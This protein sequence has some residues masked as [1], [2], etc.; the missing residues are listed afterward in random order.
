MISFTDKQNSFYFTDTSLKKILLE[1][2]EQPLLI[3]P[4][5]R[6]E[7]IQEINLL[8]EKVV[9][10]YITN[11]QLEYL[12]KIK[13]KGTEPEYLNQNDLNLIQTYYNQF[14]SK[15]KYLQHIIIKCIINGGFRVQELCDFDVKGIDSDLTRLR[16][17]G[18]GCK[19]RW[20]RIDPDFKTFLLE[21]R[22]ANN[23]LE[24][25]TFKNSYGHDYQPLFLNSRKKPFTPRHVQKFMDTVSK[26]IPDLSHKLHPHLLRHT[27]A[28]MRIMKN[29]SLNMNELCQ[30]MGHA[31]ITT[32]QIYSKLGENERDILAKRR[33]KEDK[34][35]G[36]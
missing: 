4:M 24:N 31:K 29:P 19:W 15:I 11:G 16:I 8:K 10:K 23:C 21:Y 33:E 12:N 34:N 3:I 18:K 36:N 26:A 20:T 27:Y 13:P 5:K 14:D 7:L 1:E 35:D 30:D 22:T 2:V 32:T 6:R 9:G 25:P 17:L 28:V